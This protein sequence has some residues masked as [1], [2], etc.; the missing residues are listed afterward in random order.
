MKKKLAAAA[1]ILLAA[2]LTYV[3]WRY[4]GQPIADAARDIERL[5]ALVE[6]MGWRSRAAFAGVMVLQVVLAVIPGEPLELA[7]GYVFGPWE[8]TL[9]CLAG[10]FVGSVIVFALVRRFGRKL[11]EFF[12]SKEKIDSLRFLHDPRKLYGVGSVLMVLPGTPKDLLTYC[13]G[14]TD[15]PW[16]MWLMISTLGR[17]PSIVTSTFG[18]HWLVEK[19]WAAAAALFGATAALTALGLWLYGRHT[20]RAGS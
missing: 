16:G 8:G 6:E 12:F 18:A 15:L 10:I 9:V 3:I 17:L 1:L 7:A 5:R 4:L 13:A 20:G 2:A 11:V 19:Q 14:L